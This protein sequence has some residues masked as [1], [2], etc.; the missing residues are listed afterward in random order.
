MTKNNKDTTLIEIG[1]S[2]T[3]SRQRIGYNLERVASLL[4]VTVKT[5]RSYEY[6]ERQMTVKTAA[7]LAILYGT[8]VTKLLDMHIG[9]GDVQPK[10]VKLHGYK[11]IRKSIA[12][13]QEEF[14]EEIGVSRGSLANYETGK[15]DMPVTAFIKL[16]T[17]GGLSDREVN[18]LVR[19]I[20]Y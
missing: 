15:T 17:V 1:R 11:Y 8:T 4:G 14:A 18:E 19:H 12:M 16:C 20:I 3:E 2:L 6:G 7:Q 13:T 9:D 10:D 5:L